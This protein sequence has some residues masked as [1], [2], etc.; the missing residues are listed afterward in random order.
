M[1]TLGR[2]LAILAVFSVTVFLLVTSVNT[3]GN[4]IDSDGPR[5]EQGSPEFRPPE[6][7]E[8]FRPEGGDGDREGG[9]RGFRIN[10]P[11]RLA[12]GMVKDT[13]VVGVLVTAIALPKSFFKKKKRTP[14]PTATSGGVG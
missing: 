6:G 13:I 7:G 1:K 11:R 9:S 12:T 4:L 10:N 8:N 5:F 3:L 14:K 2:T